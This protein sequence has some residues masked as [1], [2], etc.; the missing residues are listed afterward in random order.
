VPDD[1][2]VN[3][4][5]RIRDLRIAKGISQEA[6]AEKADLHRNYVGRVERGEPGVSVFVVSQLA[7]ALGLSLSEF[8]AP[9]T[10]RPAKRVG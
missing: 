5:K 10:R 6:L 9:F 3:L 1:L 2:P 4:G 8:F 7:S